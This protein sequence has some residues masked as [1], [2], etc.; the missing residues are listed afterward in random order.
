MIG[1]YA[2]KVKKAITQLTLTFMFRF[3]ILKMFKEGSHPGWPLGI[4]H[5][6]EPQIQAFSRTKMLK[7]KKSQKKFTCLQTLPNLQRIFLQIFAPI[8]LRS[9]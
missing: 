1:I 6:S 3:S 8:P 9:G 7:V 5:R 2:G 4:T